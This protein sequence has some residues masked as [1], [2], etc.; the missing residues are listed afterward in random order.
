MDLAAIRGWGAAMLISRIQS[1]QGKTYLARDEAR[2]DIISYIVMFYDWM[3]R[4]SAQGM[5]YPAGFEEFIIAFSS[6]RI[7]R[8]IQISAITSD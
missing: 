6:L 3:R 7:P 2:A 4:H 5:F 1:H 8:D